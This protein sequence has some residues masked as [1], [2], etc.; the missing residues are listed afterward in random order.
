MEEGRIVEQGT[1]DALVAK[2]GT[3][4]RMARHQMKL[5][6]DAGTSESQARSAS[7]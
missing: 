5:E 7:L 6:P 4:Y 1:H 2:R 3:Y